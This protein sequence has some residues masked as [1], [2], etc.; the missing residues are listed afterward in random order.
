[1]ERRERN[2]NKKNQIKIKEIVRRKKQKK[3][4]P[5]M[6]ILITSASLTNWEQRRG[7]KEEEEEGEENRGRSLHSCGLKQQ[8]RKGVAGKGG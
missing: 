3:S 4:V 2:K 6:G 1:M 8:M 7:R 5:V